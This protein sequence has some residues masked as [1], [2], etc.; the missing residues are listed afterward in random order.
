KKHEL[1]KPPGHLFE[2]GAVRV[3]PAGRLLRLKDAVLKGKPHTHAML[4]EYLDKFVESFEDFRME[5][6]RDSGLPWHDLVVDN[7]TRF[8]PYRDSFIDCVELIATYMNDEEAYLNLFRFLDDILQNQDFPESAMVVYDEGQDNFR[9]VIYEIFLYTIATLIR[10]KRFE[11]ALMFI[12][13]E[14]HYRQ[15]R[16]YRVG[17]AADFQETVQSLD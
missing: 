6:K 7:V 13:G 12:D 5:H 14:Y 15:R 3:K 16:E 4:D 8:L 1:G 11:R 17:T 2:E 10:A 9:F